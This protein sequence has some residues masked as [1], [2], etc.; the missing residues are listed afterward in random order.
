[1]LLSLVVC[2]EIEAAASS[3]NRTLNSSAPPPIFAIIEAVVPVGLVNDTRKW[4]RFLCVKAT[5]IFTSAIVY[6]VEIVKVLVSVV[7]QIVLSG[8]APVVLFVY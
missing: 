6:A 1:M 3:S 5:P 8:I 7:A 2:V 4:L